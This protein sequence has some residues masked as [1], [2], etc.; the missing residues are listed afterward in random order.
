MDKLSTMWHNSLIIPVFTVY[1]R[2]RL[3]QETQTEI[4]A[5]K[6]PYLFVD[7]IAGKSREKTK[8]EA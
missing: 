8:R 1:T 7:T 2:G 4:E 5:D 6:P 3:N